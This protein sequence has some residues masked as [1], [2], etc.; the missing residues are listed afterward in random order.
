MNEG[1]VFSSSVDGKVILWGAEGEVIRQ[2]ARS[3]LAPITCMQ[4][5]SA[6]LLFAGTSKGTIDVWNMHGELL[7]SLTTKSIENRSITCLSVSVANGARTYH[8]S[9]VLSGYHAVKG[10]VIGA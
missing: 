8:P 5:V 1:R 7:K 3:D 9:H 4:V 10:V 6:N 2:F